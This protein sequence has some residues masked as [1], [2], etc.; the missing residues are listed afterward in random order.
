MIRHL[1]IAL[2][3]DSDQKGLGTGSRLAADQ[4]LRL[5]KAIGAR[6]RLFHSNSQDEA[7]TPAHGDYVVT[8]PGLPEPGRIALDA[9]LEEFRQAGVETELELTEETAW[10]G[11]LRSVV[12]NQIDCVVSGKRNE[13]EHGGHRVGSVAM[14]LLRKCPC[15]VWVARP[16]VSPAPQRVLAATDLSAVGARV[17]SLAALVA[18][19]FDAALHVVHSFQLPFDV[20]WEGEE[21]V[22]D[23]ERRERESRHRKLEE[24]V[25]ETRFPGEVHYYVGLTSPTQAILACNERIDP[26]LVVMGTISRGGVAGLLVGNTAERLLARLDC[27]LL[28]VKPDDFVCPVELD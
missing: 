19:S 1:L 6:A 12:R 21:A 27:S 28:T 2:A 16:G 14:K 9:V 18:E 15:P 11:I 7:W 17:V 25:A 24:A 13:A 26:D 20:Q 4:A 10:R 23:F 3:L 8:P 22:A 5:A